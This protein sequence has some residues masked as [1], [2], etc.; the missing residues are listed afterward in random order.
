MAEGVLGAGERPSWFK[1]DKYK[2]VAAQ[3]EAYVSLESRFGSFTGA[4]KDGKYDAKLP[5]DIGV[6]IV[7]DHPLV[8]EFTKWAAENQ[9]SQVGYSTLLGMLGQYEASQ[10]PNMEVIKTQVGENADA[11]I[12]AV[13]Q[14]AKAN[15]KP[16][17]FQTF[18][19][20]TSGTN[21]AAVFKTIENMVGRTRQLSMPKINGDVPGAQPGGLAAIDARQAAKGSDGKRLYDTDPKYRAQVEA[22]RVAYFDTQRQQQ[23]VA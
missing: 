8:N 23:Q 12:T 10:L 18:R 3:A 19:E 14:W 13:G 17:E 22:D 21:A 9:L 7:A 4:P 6:T 1:A 2:S 20:A 16:E 11:R 15:M 5:E